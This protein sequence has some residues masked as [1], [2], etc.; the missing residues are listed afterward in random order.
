MIR[1]FNGIMPQIDHSAFIAETAVIIGD[2]QIGPESSIW[3]NVVVRG[4]VNYIRIG[5]R[6]N[7]Q[8]QCMLHVSSPKA[9]DDPGAP[10]TIGNDVTIGHGVTLHGCTIAENAFIGMQAII[11]DKAVVGTGA[12]IGARALVTEGT[13]I[14]P[15]TLWL[16]SPAKLKRELTSDEIIKLRK[17]AENYIGYAALYRNEPPSL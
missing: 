15:Y 9:A 16:G 4:D 5:A 11:M 7:I 13:I 14:P 8:D 6:T 3:Y 10:L 1:P 17:T 2:V 12:L